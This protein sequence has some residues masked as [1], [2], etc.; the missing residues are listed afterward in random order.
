VEDVSAKKKQEEYIERGRKGGI[1][2]KAT[3]G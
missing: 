2:R 3:G 1:E